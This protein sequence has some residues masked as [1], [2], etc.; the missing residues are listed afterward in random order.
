MD[1]VYAV[2]R[3]LLAFGTLDLNWKPLAGIIDGSIHR[4]KLLVRYIPLAQAARSLT[5][6]K[7][8]EVHHVNVTIY[9]A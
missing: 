8:I 4:R 7:A 6:D 3:F 1:L 9:C 2:L 5:A